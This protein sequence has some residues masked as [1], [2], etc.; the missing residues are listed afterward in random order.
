MIRFIELLVLLF[1]I[2]YGYAQENAGTFQS[3]Y[4]LC[5]RQ[6]Y[7]TAAERFQIQKQELSPELQKYFE[8]VLDNAFN[9][10]EKSQSTINE[11]LGNN[12]TLPDSLVLRLYQTSCDNALKKYNY[13][14]AVDAIT[15]I[16]TGY[17][18]FL[19]AEQKTDA[20]NDLKIW[21]ALKTVPPQQAEINQGV[22]ILMQKD[23]AG[24]NTLPV[25]V[26]GILINFIFDTGA[27]LSTTTQSVADS[28]GM[29]F[30]PGEI[31]AGTI[32]GEKTPAKLAVC[33]TV[34]LGNMIFTNVVFLV[35][36]DQNLTFPQINYRIFGIIG[37][38]VFEAMKEIRITRTGEFIVPKI[39]SEFSGTS[40]LALDGLTPLIFIDGRHFSFDTGADNT[41]FYKNFYDEN[42]DE[43]DQQ[44]SPV[45]IS[46][47]GAA[48]VKTVSGFSI[49][50]T[51]NLGNSS[52]TL[53]NI[54]LFKEKLKAEEFVYGN[55]GRDFIQQFESMTINFD[56]MFI[57]FE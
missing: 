34:E 14:S 10:V 57:R 19:T 29:H 33:D 16:L 15:R 39:Q 3:I 11:I 41:I 38:P 25:S 37:F 44:Y 1:L 5:Y 42:K 48:G 24:F 43:I 6:D 40:N 20:E 26:N 2:S 18:E 8:A 9:R 31:M 30:L 46:F 54:S 12:A 17:T 51:F 52:V 53:D 21:T 27:N 28:L 35:L 55:I 49:N 22:H 36:P 47:G 23:L 56:K 13:A 45:D 50:H 4:S 7:F 32:T